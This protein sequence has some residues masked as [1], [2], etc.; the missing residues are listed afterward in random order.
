MPFSP[1]SSILNTLN[2]MVNFD[3]TI[4]YTDSFGINHSVTISATENNPTVTIAEN[5]IYGF[6]SN[7]FNETVYYR[8]KNDDLKS[9]DYFN[10]IN[11]EDLYG[12]YYFDVSREIQH[13]YT[14]IA[15]SNGES[16]TYSIIVRNDWTQGRDELVKYVDYGVG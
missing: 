4:T 14:Y 13:I 3:H 9:A 10:F 5:R 15:K 6:Y 2:E 7:V 16:K 1:E 8:T 12:V 11:L